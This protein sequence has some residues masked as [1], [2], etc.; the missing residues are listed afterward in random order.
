MQQQPPL[1]Q[2]LNPSNLRKVFPADKAPSRPINSIKPDMFFTGAD[3]QSDVSALRAAPRRADNRVNNR[4]HG[5][6]GR[7]GREFF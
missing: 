3:S 2:L 5:R 4:L 6:A 1:E 7:D